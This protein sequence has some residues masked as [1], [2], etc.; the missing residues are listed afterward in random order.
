MLL[1]TWVM[2]GAAEVS[3]FLLPCACRTAPLFLERDLRWRLLLGVR[4]P[5]PWGD[6]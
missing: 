5:S 3:N 2:E 6:E 4:Q 1:M